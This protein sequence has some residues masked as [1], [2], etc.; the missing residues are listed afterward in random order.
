[1]ANKAV[2]SFVFIGCVFSLSYCLTLPQQQRLRVAG[3]IE[4]IINCHYDGARVTC[5]SMIKQDAADPMPWMLS[6]SSI[7]LCGLDYDSTTDFRC[8]FSVYDHTDSLL[9]AYEAKNGISS[10]SL[11]IKGFIN[12]VAG[13]FCLQKKEFVKGLNLGLDGIHMLQDAK[14][15]DPENFDADLFLGMYTCARAELKRTFW[16]ALFWYSGNR[17]EGISRLYTCKNK[18]SFSGLPAALLLADIVAKDERYDEAFG[19]L[20]TL[21]KQYPSSRFVKWTKAKTCA[22]K[23]SLSEAAVLYGALADEYDTIPAAFKNAC[24]AR[25]K[26]A[27]LFNELHDS[28]QARAACLHLLAKKNGHNDDVAKTIFHDTEKLFKK[29]ENDR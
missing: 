27:T 2:F 7:A 18:S 11:T 5:D 12:A 20:D 28:K 16:W 13:A 22:A 15:R 10:Y 21:E 8:F 4:Q 24:Y 23:H 9:S 26:Q 25:W 29:I 19:L 1:M 6:L 17:T 14:K 3:T